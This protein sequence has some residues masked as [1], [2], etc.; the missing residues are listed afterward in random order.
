MSSIPEGLRYTQSHEWIRDE[1]DGVVTVGITDFAQ[2]QLG[3]IVFVEVPEASAAV[4]AGE[5]VGVVESVK[6]A[7]DLYSPVSGTVEASNG[8]L[9]TGPERVNDDPYD[10]W[11]VRVRLSD[12]A[13]LNDLLSPAGYAALLPADQR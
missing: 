8:E 2:S 5:V 7:S 1:G 4:A 3:D 11:F 12:P 10:A 6:A 9:E 13:Q